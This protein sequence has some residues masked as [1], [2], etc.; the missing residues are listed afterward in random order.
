MNPAPRAALARVSG[1]AGHGDLTGGVVSAE[2]ESK[3]PASAGRALYPDG[4][5]VR[6]PGPD[7][8]P[9]P[10]GTGRLSGRVVHDGRV[11]HL[12]VD[13]V[14]FPD[15]SEGD[16]ELVRHPGAAAVVPF[17]DR[18]GSPDPAILLLRQ[19]RYASGGYLYEVPAGLP[20]GARETWAECARRELAEETGYAAA[21]VEYLTRIFT[22]PGF[23]NEVIHLFLATGLLAGDAARD[24]DEF[25]TVRMLPFS[26]ALEMVREGEIVDCKTV[27]ALLYAAAFRGCPAMECVVHREENGRPLA[28]T[29]SGRVC[30][31]N[32]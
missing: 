7:A 26:R 15:G 17:V 2:P 22:T 3:P 18:P 5:A 19:Y 4:D 21:R 16:L 27:A 14:R 11:V 31:G 32:A 1:N 8:I 12:S 23:T 25:I 10:D 20:R 13:H 24:P 6:H 30:G 9:G 28:G 29:K